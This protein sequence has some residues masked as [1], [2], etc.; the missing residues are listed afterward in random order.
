MCEKCF[1]KKAE[2]RCFSL[3][4]VYVLAFML[5][6]KFTDNT[7]EQLRDV[8]VQIIET[9]NYFLSDLNVPASRG[10]ELLNCEHFSPDVVVLLLSALQR[11]VSSKLQ[12]VESSTFCLSYTCYTKLHAASKPRQYTIL[13]KT[14]TH[15]HSRRRAPRPKPPA[16]LL[17]SIAMS[18]S[19]LSSGLKGWPDFMMW[20]LYWAW[21]AFVAPPLCHSISIRAV[22]ARGRELGCVI[23]FRAEREHLSYKASAASIPQAS[24]KN[25]RPAVGRLLLRPRTSKPANL[26]SKPSQD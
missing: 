2:T 23:W 3:W 13:W 17:V 25:P 16:L 14:N 11:T 5:E 8:F 9:W 6:V 26:Q 21:S 1:I 24:W 12:K 18:I 19:L 10:L 4:N 7:T 22:L 15:P 20:L